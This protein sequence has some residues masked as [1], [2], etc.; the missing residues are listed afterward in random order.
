VDLVASWD[1]QH[2]DEPSIK[3]VDISC[4][5]NIKNMTLKKSGIRLIYIFKIFSQQ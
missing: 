4:T 5:S 2:Y 1:G 3:E